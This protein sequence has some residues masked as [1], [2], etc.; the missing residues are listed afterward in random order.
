MANQGGNWNELQGEIG[1]KAR[2]AVL[3]NQVLYQLS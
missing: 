2:V 3:T 1:R